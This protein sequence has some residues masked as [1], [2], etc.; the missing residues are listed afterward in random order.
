[1]ETDLV[2]SGCFAAHNNDGVADR[3]GRAYVLSSTHRLPPL[4]LPCVF[5]VAVFYGLIGICYAIFGILGFLAEL[6]FER[7]RR[8]VL[9][10]FEF[11][12]RYIGRGVTYVRCVPDS[13]SA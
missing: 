5:S 10:P 6:R 9:W 2:C 13:I 8:T 12:L 11:L 1:M 4:R 3:A 7:L